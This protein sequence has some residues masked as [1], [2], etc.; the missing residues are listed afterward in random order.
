MYGEGFP[1]APCCTIY[2]LPLGGDYGL[3][4]MMDPGAPDVG[5]LEL[6][7]LEPWTDWNTVEPPESEPSE[8]TV[9]VAEFSGPQLTGRVATPRAVDEG[10]FN[11]QVFPVVQSPSGM[12]VLAGL[13]E[14]VATADARAFSIEP[15]IGQIQGPFTL[16]SA[17]A[18]TT[19]VPGV[20][21]NAPN[22]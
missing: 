22:C 6:A 8:V 11:I 5:S 10:P 2:R 4:I 21:E 18:Y 15:F 14:C 7:V 16:E 17:A 9:T 1:G 20:T 19:T 12:L 3:A 13:V